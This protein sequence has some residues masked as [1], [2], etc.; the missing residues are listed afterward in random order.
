MIVALIFN[1]SKKERMLRALKSLVAHPQNNFRIFCNGNYAFGEKTPSKQFHLILQEMF[2]STA[3]QTELENVFFDL[4]HTALTKPSII[5]GCDHFCEL[6]QETLLNKSEN[7]TR[8]IDSSGGCFYEESLLPKGCVLEK[9]LNVQKLDRLNLS[10]YEA[11]YKKLKQ[12]RNL[13]DWKYVND[14]L[15][16]IN[17]SKCSKCVIL[18]YINNSERSTTNELDL[19]PYLIASIARDCSFM[20][21]FKKIERTNR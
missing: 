2:E 6:E 1:C 15:D 5:E 14:L 8:E 10:R 12:R 17:H 19:I 4:L 18:K 9:I 7:E 13:D 16:E 3:T 11:I 21:T 20:I